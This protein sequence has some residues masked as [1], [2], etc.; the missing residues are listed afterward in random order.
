MNHL[1]VSEHVQPVLD[2]IETVEE[3]KHCHHEARL[4]TKDIEN[5]EK[6]VRKSFREGQAV[7]TYAEAEEACAGVVV[8]VDLGVEHLTFATY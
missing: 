1:V 7:Q 2:N 4:R 6:L 5:G 8:T 3:D